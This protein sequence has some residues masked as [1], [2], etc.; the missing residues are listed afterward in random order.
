MA[1]PFGTPVLLNPETGLVLSFTAVFFM[2]SDLVI[3]RFPLATKLILSFV[4]LPQLHSAA[5][6]KGVLPAV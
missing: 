1:G 3:L 2:S 5:Y 4:S 6:N